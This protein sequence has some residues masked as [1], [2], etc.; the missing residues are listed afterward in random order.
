[1]RNMPKHWSVFCARE[2]S[3]V[4]SVAALLTI[5]LGLTGQALAQGVD[6]TALPEAPVRPLTQNAG[7]AVQLGDR[8]PLNIEIR[9]EWIKGD[10][11]FKLTVPEGSSKL[12]ELGWYLDPNPLWV[13]GNVRIVV[14]PLKAG[15]QTLPTLILQSKDQD[16]VPIARTQPVS[17]TVIAP[18]KSQQGQPEL[19][20][21][22]S[23]ALPTRYLVLG[24]LAVGAIA[25]LILFAVRRFKRKTRPAIVPPAKVDEPEHVVALKRIET[26]FQYHPHSQD[27]AKPVAF[28]ISEILKDFFSKRFKIEAAESTTSEMIKLLRSV[29]MGSTD[30]QE[31]LDFFDDLDRIKFLRRE[32][33]GPYPQD[34]HRRL[35]VKAM[36]IVHRWARQVAPATAAPAAS[37]AKEAK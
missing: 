33:L 3:R 37:P 26:L 8:I 24:L 5:V 2:R 30:V 32:H 17:M 29:G 18:E 27:A 35:Q 34:V 11:Q 16:F 4:K 12:S 20:D 31:I 14:S 9:A 15:Q 25:A 7:S 13:A 36:A 28:G 10:P 1:M 21:P 23:I 19:L 6:I 22:S